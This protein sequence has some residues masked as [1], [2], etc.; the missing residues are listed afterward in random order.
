MSIGRW[1]P[2]VVDETPEIRARMQPRLVRPPAPDVSA[3]AADFGLPDL[4]W[5]TGREKRGR[6]LSPRERECLTIIQAGA[7]NKQAAH[8]M[9]ITEQTIKNV[10][11]S[12]LA[13]LGAADRTAAVVKAMAMGLIGDRPDIAGITDWL[14]TVASHQADIATLLAGVERALATLAAATPPIE[15]PAPA[16][17]RVPS[18]RPT[19]C[20]MAGCSEPVAEY[21]GRGRP[22]TRC[23]RH[24]VRHVA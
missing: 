7:T 12:I 16:R 15:E 21:R 8:Q 1:T 10:M 24:V 9:G 14:A 11:S 4:A 22:P 23:E 6:R 18:I 17:A 2:H 19:H 20:A 3:P 13:K 5:T